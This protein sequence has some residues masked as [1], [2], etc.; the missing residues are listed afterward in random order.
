MARRAAPTPPINTPSQK[1]RKS[2]QRQRLLAGMVAAANRDGYAGA[3]VSAVIAA[4]GVS[5]PTFYDYFAEK[6]DCFVAAVADAQ[7]RLLAD[8]RAGV[9]G[10][11]PER[12]AAGTVEALVAFAVSEPAMARFLMKEALAGG[13]RAKSCSWVSRA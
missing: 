11:P 8:V 7:G 13:R 10:G 9:E 5:R 3:N 4:A 2:T 1:G 6:D 12:A